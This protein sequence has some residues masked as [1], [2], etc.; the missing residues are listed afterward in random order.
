MRRFAHGPAGLLLAILL[1]AGCGPRAQNPQPATQVRPR[2][3]ATLRIL[4]PSPGATVTARTLQVRLRLTGATVTPET[5]THLTPDRG[6]VHL[7]LDGRVVSMSYGLD[8][9][10]PVTPGDH[11]LQA[12]FVA[13][14]HFPFNP[15]VVTSATFTVK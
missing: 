12:E 15:R 2:S 6:H 1:L 7:I 5:S 9:N 13:T 10:V 11:L 3:T 8:Q 4:T 14:D